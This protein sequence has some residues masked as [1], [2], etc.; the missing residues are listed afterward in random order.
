MPAF[1]ALNIPMNEGAAATDQDIAL[2]FAA[3]GDLRNV[4]KTINGLPS[5]YTGKCT[6]VINDIHPLV[7]IR[8][9]VLLLILLD[10]SGPSEDVAAEVAL[11][12]LYSSKITATQHTFL[13]SLIK[14][15]EELERE[16]DVESAGQLALGSH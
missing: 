11:H 15:V 14:R 13:Q 5:D 4:I 7:A 12:V 6:L 9:I 1:D 3:S 16:R 8:S 10:P 2:C